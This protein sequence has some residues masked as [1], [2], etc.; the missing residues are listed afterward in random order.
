MRTSTRF[1]AKLLC[2]VAIAGGLCAAGVAGVADRAQATDHNEPQ[3][4]NS[5][6][7]DPLDSSDDT[8]SDASDIYGN[9]VWPTD[10]SVVFI[11]TWPAPPQGFEYLAPGEPLPEV[12]WDEGHPNAYDPG[13]LYATHL[14]RDTGL[15]IGRN[16]PD[17][18]YTIFSR[19]AYDDEHRWW[20]VRVDGIPGEP[21]P[22]EGPVGVPLVGEGGARVQAGLFDE[23]F[24]VDLERFFE[25]Q[26]V[27]DEGDLSS[28]LL[29][30]RENV[31]FFVGYN[32]HALVVE[33]P[34]ENVTAFLRRQLNVWTTTHRLPTDRH[35]RP[36]PEGTIC[37]E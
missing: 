18:E 12:D 6:G 37:A 24:F 17:A 28:A 4:I 11:I 20:G 22:I 35:I 30:F 36:S 2:A 8:F 16:I 7:V 34:K 3:S 32:V 5:L 27:R 10:D 29:E 19:F 23:P 13:V 33:V 9:F 14:D 15:P 25:G 31:D 21:G 26:I 1:H